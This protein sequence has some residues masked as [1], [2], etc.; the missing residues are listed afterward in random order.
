M[1]E[2]IDTCLATS[3]VEVAFDQNAQQ[4]TFASID[5]G[6]VSEGLQV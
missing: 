5:Y 1:S 6:Y 3:I 2:E 4:R